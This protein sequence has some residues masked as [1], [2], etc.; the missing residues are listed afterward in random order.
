MSRKTAIDTNKLCK[1]MSDRIDSD[2]KNRNPN[3]SLYENM[4]WD[5]DV[6]ARKNELKGLRRGL[7]IA[8]SLLE[9]A[10]IQKNKDFTKEKYNDFL[11]KLEAIYASLQEDL[12]TGIR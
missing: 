3:C 4:L 10:K 9:Y 8:D 5:I 7:I 2:S 11:K 12:L 6:Y 1:K